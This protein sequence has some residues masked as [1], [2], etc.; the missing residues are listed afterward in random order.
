MSLEHPWVIRAQQSRCQMS[1]KERE[2][3]LRVRG[4]HRD[5]VSFPGTQAKP[6]CK[7]VSA[8]VEGRMLIRPRED[9]MEKSGI[10]GA[11]LTPVPGT[12]PPESESSG[13]LGMA[14]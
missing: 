6:A 5:K 9:M 14:S 12:N 1:L 7:P 3:S 10:S 4:R 13:L 11:A 8:D 2:A